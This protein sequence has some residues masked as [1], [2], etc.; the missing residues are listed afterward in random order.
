M[1]TENDLWKRCEQI[2]LLGTIMYYTSLSLREHTM[3][4]VRQTLA[5]YRCSSSSLPSY[6]PFLFLLTRSISFWKIS[7]LFWSTT[8]ALTLSSSASAFRLNNCNPT[9]HNPLQLETRG[10]LSSRHS[11]AGNLELEH[12]QKQARRPSYSLSL[13]MMAS[14]SSNKSTEAT[15]Y[16][17]ALSRAASEALQ[18]PVQLEAARGG[19]ASGGGGATTS[20]VC[21]VGNANAKYFV[22]TASGGSDMLRAEYLGIKAMY[23]TNTVRVPRPIAFGEFQ[24]RAFVIFEYLEFCGGGSQYELG[25]QLARMHR[26]SLQDEFGFDVDNTIGATTQPNLPWHND[27]ADFWDEH[28]LGHMLRLTDNAGGYSQDKIDKLRQKTHEML[29]QH[30]PRASLVHGDLWGGNKGFC[31]GDDG[32]KVVPVIFDPATY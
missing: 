19:G 8:L 9:H 23:E 24:N 16:M 30:K 17:E 4:A 6:S 1:A 20:A 31:R 10:A 5:L 15:T 11:A 2:Q 18:R 29:S 22:K 32:N 27:W 28:R 3:M 12:Q 21:E 26:A 25:Q 7:L 14:S 13:C